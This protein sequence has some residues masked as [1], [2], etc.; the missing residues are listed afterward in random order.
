MRKLGFSFF[1]LLAMTTVIHA[2]SVNTDL[3]EAAMRGDSD[4]VRSL[5]EDG[6]DVNATYGDGSTALHWAAG[7]GDLELT[8]ML[9]DAGARVD[10]TT[11]IG[12]ITSLFMA[13]KSGEADVIKTL[14]E[15][16]ANAN[17]SNA[18]GTT[19]LMSAAA[20]GNRDAV[21]TLIDSGADV[22]AAEQTN[23][24]TALMFA[25]NL[26]RAEAI[27]V[28]LENG[29]DA[30]V[31]TKVSSLPSR[32]RGGRGSAPGVVGGMTALHFAARDGQMES[33]RELIAGGADVNVPT[34]SNQT[35][36]ITE[37][38]INANLDIA[39]LL[40]DNG[41][42]VNSQNAD[43]LAPLY[44]TV[45][46]RWRTNTWYPQPNVSEKKTSYLDLMEEILAH[47]A[48]VNARQAKRLWFRNFRYS[49]D[50]VEPSGA[51]ALW[52]AAQA[53]DVE[54]MRLLAK[55]NANPTIG[56]SRGVTPLMVAAGIGFEYQAT[57]I[58]PASRMAA[59]RYLVEE[60]G[61][62][63]NSKDVQDYSVLHGAAYVGDNDV[64]M[65]LVARGA[66][67]RARASGSMFG[68]RAAVNVETGTG[69]TVADMANGP[70]E[71]SLL[72]PDTVELLEHLGSEN[73]HD[74][75]STACIGLTK[76]DKP[77]GN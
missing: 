33:V 44:A 72:H 22:N 59:V 13:A 34:K 56:T 1:A 43:G 40:L 77:S 51:T 8:R 16:G 63:V 3:V 68:T 60:L 41:A 50:W 67:V 37:A 26:N 36:P 66:D 62:D 25:A 32:R 17:E 20:A 45:D 4:T 71:K 15:A 58:S 42:E 12:S 46:I 49:G 28:L 65:Y 2:A 74:C 47:G 54:A 69:D 61:A 48:D 35:P 30:D 11:R 10:A 75:R 38:I 9:L 73:S 52:R 6:A 21:L 23:G 7:N 39:K 76:E 14:I 5:L 29:A 57:N 31:T 19:V 70:R 64:V 27:R 24:Q 55:H 53:N 18:N